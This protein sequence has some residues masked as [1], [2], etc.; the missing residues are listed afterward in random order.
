MAAAVF[1]LLLVGC[2]PTLNQVRPA[3][4][5][6]GDFLGTLARE[7][8][9]HAIFLGRQGVT[10]LEAERFAQKAETAIAGRIPEPEPAADPAMAAVRARLLALLKTPA[11]ERC[12]VFAAL[13][14]ARY[15]AWA[16]RQRAWPGSEETRRY[17][18]DAE[19]NLAALGGPCSQAG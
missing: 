3:R 19:E 5:D 13:A 15:D 18:R 7:E 11:K 10:I 2:A 17:Q 8:R 16:E 9:R 12:P 6:H 1:L 14:L 4:L